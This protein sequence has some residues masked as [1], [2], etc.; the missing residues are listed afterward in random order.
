MLAGDPRPA[1]RRCGLNTITEIY[2]S[3]RQQRSPV[4]LSLINTR[5]LLE[6]GVNLRSVTADQDRDPAMVAKVSAVLRGMGMNA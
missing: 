3:L 2:R 6:T 1:G 4:Q 5:I